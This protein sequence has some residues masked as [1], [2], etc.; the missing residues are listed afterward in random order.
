METFAQFTAQGQRLYGM[1]H[2]PDSPAP[3]HGW[4]SVVLLH[5]LTGNRTEAH[6][7]F[8]LLSRRLAAQGVASL[9]FDFRGSGESQGDFGSAAVGTRV[10][11]AQTAAEY[12]RRQPGLDPERVSLLGYSLGALVA[13]LALGGVRPH[14][15]ALWAPALPT[16]WLSVLRGGFLPPVVTDAGGWPLGRAFLEEVTRSRPLEAAA[17]WGGVARVFHGDG[18]EVCPPAWGVGYA[19]ALR[20]DAVAIPG[21]GHTFGTLTHLESLHHETAR[22]LTGQG[23]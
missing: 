13:C 1:L 9:R 20:C 18:D 6:R 3:A 12:V 23:A 21:A 7:S 4:P 10:Q 19:R 2:V 5:G 11:D 17:A 15:L 8:V 16:L 22:F 14:R